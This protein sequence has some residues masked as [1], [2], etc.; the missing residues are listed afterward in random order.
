M[1]IEPA[2]ADAGRLRDRVQRRKVI[3]GFVETAQSRLQNMLFSIFPSTRHTLYPL[4]KF[5]VKV[6]VSRLF[7]NA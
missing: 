4:Y 2:L 1:I 7:K 5:F 3:A 6:P